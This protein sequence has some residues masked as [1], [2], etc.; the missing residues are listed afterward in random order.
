VKFKQS[1]TQRLVMLVRLQ[2]TQKAVVDFIKL[3]NNILIVINY[4]EYIK[5]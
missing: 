4:I 2:I 5:N 1:L 3:Q